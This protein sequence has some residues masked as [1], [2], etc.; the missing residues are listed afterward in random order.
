MQPIN[1]G[2]L[3]IHGTHVTANN[4]INNNI[5]FFSYFRFEKVYY[6]NYSSSITTPWTT[7]ENILHHYLFENKII[8]NC[9]SKI[10]QEF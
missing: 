10:S 4:S 5:V 6:N 1:I 7:E 2:C 9:A 8:Q 3:D